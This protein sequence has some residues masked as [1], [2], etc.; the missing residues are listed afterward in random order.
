MR[1]R[2]GIGEALCHASRTCE[3]AGA[4]A[5]K[6]D[7]ST[8]ASEEL[9]FLFY[10]CSVHAVTQSVWDMVLAPVGYDLPQVGFEVE[11]L[12]T[13]RALVEVSLDLLA[14]VVRELSIEIVVQ[15]V[16]RLVAVDFF[17]SGSH[18]SPLA[19]LL[20][21]LVAGLGAS[22]QALRYR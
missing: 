11:G 8:A 5:I 12:E 19:L 1:R 7:R 16:Q 21:A 14:A 6:L 17:L 18:C 13:R 3:P 22:Y 2:G 15:P 20:Q 4:P 9:A 10:E